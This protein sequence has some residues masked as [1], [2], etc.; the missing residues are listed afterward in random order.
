VTD[1]NE[2]IV[3]KGA[4]TGAVPVVLTIGSTTSQKTATITLQ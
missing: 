1:P 2:A 3:P 4:G